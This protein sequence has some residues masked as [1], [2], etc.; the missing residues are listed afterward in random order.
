MR[1]QR[2]ARHQTDHQVDHQDQ[3]ELRPQLRLKQNPRLY[4]VYQKRRQQ[5]VQSAAD[6]HR[7]NVAAA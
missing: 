5:T 3:K 4:A 7:H 2:N 1:G 6:A